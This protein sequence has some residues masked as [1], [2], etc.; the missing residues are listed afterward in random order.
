MGIDLRS[1]WPFGWDCGARS[2]KYGWAVPGLQPRVE[3]LGI[4][5]LPHLLDFAPPSVVLHGNGHAILE[6][7]TQGLR[8]PHLRFCGFSR[9]DM[10]THRKP[11]RVM[12]DYDLGLRG[13]GL[14]V[15]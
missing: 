7:K 3:G 8:N 5:G 12:S 4:R 10:V 14:E 1:F 6:L 2:S 9:G 11:G 13:V 15:F